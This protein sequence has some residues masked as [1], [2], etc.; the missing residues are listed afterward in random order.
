MASSNKAAPK[1]NPKH[2]FRI[3]R[4]DQAWGPA[5][6]EKAE[7]EA[8]EHHG[9]EAKASRKAKQAERVVD[10]DQAF[11][12]ACVDD[13]LITLARDGGYEADI[14]DGLRVQDKEQAHAEALREAAA[15]ARAELSRISNIDLA[16]HFTDL[17]MRP[18]L[19][20]K[21]CAPKG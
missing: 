16:L 18:P 14:R 17:P 15:I 10:V 20:C 12:Q 11:N 19:C 8:V 5:H 13:V 9:Q 21:F 4:A 7:R 1:A 2:L 6:R 3:T